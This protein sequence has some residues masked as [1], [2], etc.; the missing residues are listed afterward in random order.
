[1]NIVFWEDDLRV[2]VNEEVRVDIDRCLLSVGPGSLPHRLT[3]L[4]PDEVVTTALT[5]AKVSAHSNLPALRQTTSP[6]YDLHMSKK[7][8][9]IAALGYCLAIARKRI[10]GA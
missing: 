3:R 4:D 8:V 2:G 7:L 6:N 10:V 1:M 5:R 9:I